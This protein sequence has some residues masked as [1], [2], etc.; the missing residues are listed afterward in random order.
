ML[1]FCVGEEQAVVT[2]SQ[3]PGPQADEWRV[4]LHSLLFLPP[5]LGI[6]EQGTV[7]PAVHGGSGYGSPQ[8]LLLTHLILKT[9]SQRYKLTSSKVPQPGSHKAFQGEWTPNSTPWTQQGA[10][11]ASSLRDSSNNKGLVV[12]L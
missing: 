11:H 1:L 9:E 3:G 2:M 4:R 6:V 8:L 7:C 10:V 5:W 12:F